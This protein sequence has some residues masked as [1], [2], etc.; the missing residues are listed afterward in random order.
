MRLSS[1]P[2]MYPCKPVCTGVCTSPNTAWIEN[3]IAMNIIKTNHFN[4]T[5]LHQLVTFAALYLLQHLKAWF[6]TAKGSL[7]DTSNTDTAPSNI[8]SKSNSTHPITS[9]SNVS[10]TPPNQYFDNTTNNNTNNTSSSSHNNTSDADANTS[11]TAAVPTSPHPFT[12]PPS[13]PRQ[14]APSGIWCIIG[15]CNL[16]LASVETA[17][18]STPL[19]PN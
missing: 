4:W 15:D 12:F 8:D 11:T 2:Q 18:P 14:A 10:R 7:G 1:H 16:T 5:R 19:S 6:P 13:P 9:E 17:N 3:Q